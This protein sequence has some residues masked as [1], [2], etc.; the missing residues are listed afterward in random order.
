MRL[1]L[2]TLTALF[3]AAA[4]VSAQ[5]NF[6]DLAGAGEALPANYGG[7]SWSGFYAVDG[8]GLAPST[9]FCT[10]TV[11]P[12]NVIWGNSYASIFSPTPFAFT[13]VWLTSAYLPFLSVDIIGS[14]NGI[15][16][17]WVTAITFNTGP[18]FVNPFP[19]G[20]VDLLQFTAADNFVLDDISIVSTEATAVPEPATMTLLATGLAGMVAAR[21]RRKA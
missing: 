5:V 15:P 14:L 12:D 18:A 21:R 11:S 3:L 17:F 19:A 9:G 7:V 13:G 4:P 1:A 6:D 2:G 8:C 10:G 16:Q 20:T